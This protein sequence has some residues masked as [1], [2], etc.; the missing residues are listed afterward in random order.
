VALER[1][2]GDNVVPSRAGWGSGLFAGGLAS[3]FSGVVRTPGLNRYGGRTTPRSPTGWLIGRPS[4]RREY[5]ACQSTRGASLLVQR[6]GVAR[7]TGWAG[8]LGWDALAHV[9]D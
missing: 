3:S 6:F 4:V 2:S 1:T 9:F 5:S 8:A 7:R